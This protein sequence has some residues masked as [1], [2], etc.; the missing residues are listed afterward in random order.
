MHKRNIKFESVNETSNKKVD[1]Y[2]KEEE[3]QY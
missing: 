2:Q 3:K 1:F